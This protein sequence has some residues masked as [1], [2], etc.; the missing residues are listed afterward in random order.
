[1]LSCT[2]ALFSLV[3]AAMASRHAHGAVLSLD[4]SAFAEPTAASVVAWQID[5]CNHFA[6]QWQCA[7]DGPMVCGRK[8]GNGWEKE[9]DTGCANCYA[10]TATRLPPNPPGGELNKGMNH[11]PC[12]PF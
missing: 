6:S 2:A 7:K 11:V 4:V 10:C 5:M 1:M 12:S 9:G 8:R 3:A